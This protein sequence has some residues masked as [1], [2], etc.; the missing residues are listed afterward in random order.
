V[1][2]RPGLP[3][4]QDSHDLAVRDGSQSS[5]RRSGVPV[6][7]PRLLSLLQ[8]T[9]E[10]EASSSLMRRPG[11]QPTAATCTS[12][13]ARITA[14]ASLA[15]ASRG[16]TSARPASAQPWSSFSA[17]PTAQLRSKRQDQSPT[18][19]GSEPNRHVGHK[20][21]RGNQADTEASL[22][23]SESRDWFVERVGEIRAEHEGD[24]AQVDGEEEGETC[25]P[26]DRREVGGPERYQPSPTWTAWCPRAAA[27]PPSRAARQPGR[28]R[29]R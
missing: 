1:L 2:L 24:R 12:S 29:G 26:V 16:L 18:A 7:Y 27:A 23:L 6:S 20:P 8:Q 3:R 9:A 17:S 14:N 21:V 11:V 19:A 15:R 5:K 10:S 28:W 13:A 4:K 22:S 25:R